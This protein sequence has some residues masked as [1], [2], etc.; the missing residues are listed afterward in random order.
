MV[1]MRSRSLSSPS[2]SIFSGVSATREQGRRRL[3]DAVVGRLRREHH[4]DQQGE[5]IDRIEFALGLGIGRAEAAENLLDLVAAVSRVALA[6]EYPVQLPPL[7]RT[8]P[9]NEATRK[10]GAPC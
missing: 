4:R 10:P 3:V 7:G 2:A 9:W 6:M 5:G 1:L 8:G